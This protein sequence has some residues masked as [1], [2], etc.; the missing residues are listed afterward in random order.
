MLLCELYVNN[1]KA[2]KSIFTKNFIVKF[3]LIFVLYILTV[4]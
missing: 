1:I 3:P 2:L 4:E